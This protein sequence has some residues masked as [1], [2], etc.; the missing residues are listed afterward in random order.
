MAKYHL[1]YSGG[2]PMPETEE[3]AAE[4]MAAWNGWFGQLGQNVT[5]GGNPFGPRQTIA[6][7]GSVSDAGGSTGYSII[8]AND[9][10]AAVEMSKGC[11][12]LANG[13]NVE[14]SEC[15]DM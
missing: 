7:D 4:V 1:T 8:T 5:D 11:P 13:G 2:G 15:I 14:V 6:A 3:G 10:A 9:L 12:V